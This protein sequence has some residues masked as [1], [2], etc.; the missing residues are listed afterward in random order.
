MTVIDVNIG[1]CVIIKDDVKRGFLPDKMLYNIGLDAAFTDLVCVSPSNVVFGMSDAA[2]FEGQLAIKERKERKNSEDKEEEEEETKGRTK[3]GNR[4]MKKGE[5][6][7]QRQRRGQEQEQRQREDEVDEE[8]GIYT[9]RALIVPVYYTSTHQHN[10]NTNNTYKAL[11]SQILKN[12]INSVQ[13]EEESPSVLRTQSAAVTD[14]MPMPMTVLSSTAPHSAPLPFPSLTTCGQQQ[15]TKLLKACTGT[16]DQPPLRD[17]GGLE[18]VS[19][20][21]QVT[22][23]SSLL[24]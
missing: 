8:E 18:K 3:E 22:P 16:S 12:G 23:L 21:A 13:R 17:P 7:A 2:M 1:S 11:R 6:E 5:E 15:S 10:E 9:P 19:F 20:N 14:T 24:I 4:G